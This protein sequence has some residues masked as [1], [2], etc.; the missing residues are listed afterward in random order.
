MR[1]LTQLWQALER[2]PGL[3]DVPAYWKHHAGGDYPFLHP[4]LRVTD[5]PGA[6]Y[7]CPRIQ[8]ADCPRR[9]IDHGGGAFA[10]VCRHPHRLCDDV[11]LASADAM[12]RRLELGSFLKQVLPVLGLRWQAPALC[13]PGVW[14]VGISRRIDTRNHAAFLQIQ[15][16][17]AAFAEGVRKL[18]IESSG[19][20]V[21]LAPT[22]RFRDVA[23]QQMIQ[24]R[25]IGFI[26]LEDQ[27][28]VDGNGQ[29]VAVDPVSTDDEHPVTPPADRERVLNVFCQKCDCPKT[30]VAD[31][32]EVDPADLYKWV[33]D[34]LPKKSKKSARIEALLR[35]GILKPAR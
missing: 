25:G 15:G 18:L 21:L 17:S 10:A 35:R 11:A 3:S 19:P 32:A 33:R 7:P 31:E 28:L 9:I 29:F 16:R 8:N 23:V 30:K 34:E 22:E 24:A 20:F 1:K 12:Q 5:E 26:S 27:L 14:A 13:S 2:V 4:H 6:R